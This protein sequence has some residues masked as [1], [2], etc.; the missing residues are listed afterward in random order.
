[1]G[2]V[3]PGPE[4]TGSSGR[5]MLQTDAQVGANACQ[6]TSVDRSAQANLAPS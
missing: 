4:A 6:F 2:V 3:R 1:M 5:F